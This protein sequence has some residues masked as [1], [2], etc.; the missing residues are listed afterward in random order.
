MGTSADDT[1]ISSPSSCVPAGAAGSGLGGGP[2]RADREPLGR[3]R[4]PRHAPY[5][6]ELVALA[7]DVILAGVG[8]TVAG[9]ATG[10]PHSADRFRSAI[11]P[12]GAGIV[13]SLARPGGNATGFT[14]LRIQLEREM[15]GAAQRDP[16]ARDTRAVLRELGRRRWYRTMGGHSGRGVVIRGGREPDRR[17]DPAEIERDISA[18]AGSPNSGMIVTVSAR[19]RS[20]AS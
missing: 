5:A 17:R 13:E 4:S 15:A 10:E 1:G 9:P 19:R 12:V 6:E 16:A 3:G 11:D 7:P 2:Q 8:A 14:Q 20:I 18:F